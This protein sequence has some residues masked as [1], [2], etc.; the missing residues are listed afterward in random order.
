MRCWLFGNRES[1]LEA[2]RRAGFRR[3]LSRYGGGDSGRETPDFEV[4]SFAE[5]VTAIRGF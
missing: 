5:F 4:G 2:A 1:D 3:V